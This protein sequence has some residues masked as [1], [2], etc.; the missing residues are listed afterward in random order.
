MI[1]WFTNKDSG[2]IQIKLDSFYT[3]AYYVEHSNG[4][5][6]ITYSKEVPTVITEYVLLDIAS[7]FNGS[8]FW[9]I[10]LN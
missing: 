2:Y 7:H 5:N 6:L 9:T 10:Q 1:Q 8:V 4:H 3:H